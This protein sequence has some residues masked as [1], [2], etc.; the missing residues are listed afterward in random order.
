[1]TNEA[2][3]KRWTS[4]RRVLVAVV[5]VLVL[6]GGFAL[7]RRSAIFGPRL[8]GGVVA[9]RVLT[10]YAAG[11]GGRAV[12]TETFRA[13]FPAATQDYASTYGS[14]NERVPYVTS[15]SHV[16]GDTFSITVVDYRGRDVEPRSLMQRLVKGF[17][18]GKGNEVLSSTS[19]TVD[20]DPTLDYIVKGP[21]RYFHG[22]Q[23]FIDDRLY[24]LL[25][26]SRSRD[27]TG[28]KRFVESFLPIE[29]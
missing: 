9:K 13:T 8:R 25:V 26:T 19:R 2:S 5:I 18:T 29:A 15:A 21:R 22:R 14:G 24:H 23:L 3:P 16:A 12:T 28:Y 1:V 10:E 17:S 4:R 27:A 20:G 7:T 11:R 6:L